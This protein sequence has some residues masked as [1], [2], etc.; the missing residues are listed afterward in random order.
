LGYGCLDWSGFRRLARR[1]SGLVGGPWCWPEG[2]R[3]GRTS[4]C[5]GVNE[6]PAGERIS[7][8]GAVRSQR[9]GVESTREHSQRRRRQAE[10]AARREPRTRLRIG[11]KHKNR[12]RK[13]RD[14]L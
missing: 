6:R 13:D 2:G 1:L 7:T 4:R 12:E 9:P 5:S 14:N 11:G 3:R 8:V 10:D